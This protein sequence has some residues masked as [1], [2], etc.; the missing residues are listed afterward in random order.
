VPHQYKIRRAKV[1][2]RQI[3]VLRWL[4]KGKRLSEVAVI[5]GI[6]TPTARFHLYRV[7]EQLDCVTPVQTVAVAIQAGLIWEEQ[8]ITY[9]VHRSA[10]NRNHG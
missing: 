3:E 6:K 4:A 5:L 2:Y 10:G 1:T 7:M 9:A 8:E